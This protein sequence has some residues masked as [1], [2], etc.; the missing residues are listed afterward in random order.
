MSNEIADE[1]KMILGLPG[2][3]QMMGVLFIFIGIIQIGFIPFKKFMTR[4]C[5]SNN[6]KV[7]DKSVNGDLN[8]PPEISPLIT[9]KPKNGNSSNG[10]VNRN[11]VRS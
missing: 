11:V 5:C 4:R 9:E 2:Q 8:P 1:V 10:K 7:C 3:G 6:S